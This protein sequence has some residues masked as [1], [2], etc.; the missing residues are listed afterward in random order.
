MVGSGTPAHRAEGH[1]VAAEGR[2]VKVRKVEARKN[3]GGR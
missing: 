1:G 3:V 2:K